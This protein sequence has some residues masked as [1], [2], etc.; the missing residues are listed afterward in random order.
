MYYEY[1]LGTP[2][3]AEAGFWWERLSRAGMEIEEGIVVRSL[4][5]GESL[6][7]CWGRIDH[8]D[9]VFSS[10]LLASFLSL[11]RNDKSHNS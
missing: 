3:K 4:Q 11:L 6:R 8:A 7:E 5:I 1:A 2:I 9:D 10:T